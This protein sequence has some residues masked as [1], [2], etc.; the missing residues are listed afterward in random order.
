MKVER[1]EIKMSRRNLHRVEFCNCP[2]ELVTPHAMTVS[3]KVDMPLSGTMDG[4]L[5]E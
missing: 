5:D 4:A 1:S 2:M 3:S